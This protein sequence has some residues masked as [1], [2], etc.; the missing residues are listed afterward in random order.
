MCLLVRECCHSGPALIPPPVVVVWRFRRYNPTNPLPTYGGNNLVLSVRRRYLISDL[1]LQSHVPTRPVL[2]C[3]STDA[4]TTSMC[5][6]GCLLALSL[7]PCGPEDQRK[8]EDGR[9]DVLTYVSDP[10][11]SNMAITGEIV[12]L[13]FVQSSANGRR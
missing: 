10:L 8:V 9:S 3:S 4:W 7:Q 1:D 2:V 6:W 11:T 13:L 12:V 5:A